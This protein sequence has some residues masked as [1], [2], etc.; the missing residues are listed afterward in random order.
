MAEPKAAGKRAKACG[1]VA[2]GTTA[3][4]VAAGAFVYLSRHGRG[5]AQPGSAPALGAG[6][7]R[8]ESSRPDQGSFAGEAGGGPMAQARILKP[9]KSAMQSGTAETRKWVLEYEPAS[10]RQP[11]PLMGW[12]SALDTLNQV[13][14][15]FA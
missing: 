4:L 13:R 11:D 6:C 8:F 2:G 15:R 5:V 9:A 10:K 1:H 3:A 14:L 7:G 12:T